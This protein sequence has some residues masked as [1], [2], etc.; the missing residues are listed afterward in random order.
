MWRSHLTLALRSLLR[1]R[2]VSTINIAGLSSALAVCVLALLFVRHET[3]YDAWHEKGDRLYVPVVTDADGD[4]HTHLSENN[5][6]AIRND[7]PAVA[8]A[9]YLRSG[10][11]AVSIGEETFHQSVNAVDP[12]FLDMFTFPLL[13][14]HPAT[15]LSRPDGVVLTHAVARQ[16]YGDEDPTGSTIEVSGAERVVTGVMAPVPKTSSF[17]FNTRLSG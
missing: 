5:R 14:G 11:V 1:H 2:L 13:S 10:W 15:A 8:N 16:F 7:V 3:A 17:Y 9:A 12:A 4:R 6:A